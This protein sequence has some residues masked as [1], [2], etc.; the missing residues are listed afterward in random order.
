MD[1]KFQLLILDILA[2]LIVQHKRPDRA[3]KLLTEIF[4]MRDEIKSEEE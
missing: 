4:S 2:Y 1:K 3:E